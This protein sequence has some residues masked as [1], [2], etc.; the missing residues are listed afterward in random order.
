MVRLAGVSVRVGVQLGHRRV[1]CT[2]RDECLFRVRRRPTG[3][4][5]QARRLRQ[6]GVD[7]ANGLPK[8]ELI[9]RDIDSEQRHAVD[10]HAEVLCVRVRAT[11][12]ARARTHAYRVG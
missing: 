12:C 5:H 7:A 2:K 3:G 6:L 10:G 4:V 1:E 8:L 11:A 9:V